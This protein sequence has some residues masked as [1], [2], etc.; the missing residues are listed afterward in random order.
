MNMN[1]PMRILIL[2]F[3]A[4]WLAVAPQAQ[5]AE[6][7]A[8]LTVHILDYVAVD[9]E[10]AVRDGAVIDAGEYREMQD[11]TDQVVAQVQGLPARAQQADL[12]AQAQALVQRVQD[13]AGADEIARRANDLRRDVIAAYGVVVAPRSAPDSAGAAARYA[14]TCA[15]C[16]GATGHGDGPQAAGLDPVPADFHDDSRMRARSVYGLYNSIT[17]GVNGTS[18]AA[19]AGLSEDERWAL[20]FYVA[21]LRTAQQGIADGKVLWERGVGRDVFTDLRDV[22]ALSTNDAV[23][24]GGAQMAEVLAYLVHEPA[25]AAASKASPIDTTR[26]VLGQSMAAYARGERAAAQRLAVSAYLEGFELV[27]ASL[28]TL[29]AKLRVEVENEMIKLRTQMRDGAPVAAVQAQMDVVVGLL[30]RVESLLGE[31]ELSAS[32]AALASFIILLREGMEAILVLA[33]VFAFLVKAGR[34]DAL[35]W[36]HA[37]WITALAL[38][39]LTWFAASYLIEISGAGRE[40]TEGITALIAAAVLLYVGFWLHSKAYAQAWQ[41]YV[42]E[43]LDGALSRGTLWALA[44][45]SFLAVYREVFE[46][47][48]FYQALWTQAG[49]QG[50]P[51]VIGG[52]FAAVAALAVVSWLIFRYGIRLP[53]GV[54]FAVSSALMAL[55]AVVF[56]GKGVAALQEAGRVTIDVVSFP[57]VP[58]LGMYPTEQ[59][60]LAQLVVLTIVVLGFAWGYRSARRQAQVSA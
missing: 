52:F 29:D 56:V 30:V 36:V 47:V 2:L 3:A 54:F 22:T 42:R 12:L 43:K 23:A 15:A 39:F 35:R 17:L 45:I 46:V 4:C 11:F 37:G 60:L 55:L 10:G 40:L 25:A 6:A 20:A 48:L 34:R 31:Q 51:A 59:S 33:A 27:E 49:T 1:L 28:D 18:M 5:A 8:E 53:L 9:Y 50:G 44:S 58:A 41:R 21:G 7:S 26:T 14:S 24:R 13:K 38:G 19:Y 57:R 16:H 32:A